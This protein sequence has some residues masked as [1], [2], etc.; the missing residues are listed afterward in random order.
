MIAAADAAYARRQSRRRTRPAQAA[1]ELTPANALQAAL[2][3][4]Q[5]AVT[6]A[7]QAYQAAMQLALQRPPGQTRYNTVNAEIHD[8]TGT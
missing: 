7:N 8:V 4:I 1:A 5:A 6:S 3:S 2:T